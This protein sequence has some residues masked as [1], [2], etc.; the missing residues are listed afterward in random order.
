VGKKARLSRQIVKRG[1][2]NGKKEMATETGRKRGGINGSLE[3]KKGGL[4]I[5][6]GDEGEKL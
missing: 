3:K 4:G 5:L 1:S 6:S 2:Q